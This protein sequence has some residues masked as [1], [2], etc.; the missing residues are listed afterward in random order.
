MTGVVCL[1]TD[2]LYGVHR[3]GGRDSGDALAFAVLWY[4]VP[5]VRRSP[6]PRTSS[7]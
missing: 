2:V 7:T 3:D 1:I 4:V 5:I 6:Q